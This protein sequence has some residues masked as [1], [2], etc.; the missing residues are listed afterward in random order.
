[1][2]DTEC[3]RGTGVKG[4]WL[5]LNLRIVVVG[6]VCRGRVETGILG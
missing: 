4:A 6:G 1:M 3:T 5:G 2:W